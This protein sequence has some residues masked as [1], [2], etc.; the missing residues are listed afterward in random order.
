MP[1]FLRSNACSW[2]F[3]VLYLCN[4]SSYM[5]LSWPLVDYFTQGLLLIGYRLHDDYEIGK[6]LC[7]KAW[8]WFSCLSLSLFSCS[9]KKKLSLMNFLRRDD[10]SNKLRYSLNKE[11]NAV[12]KNSMSQNA[13][14][15]VIGHS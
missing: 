6:Q 7:S 10:L 15:G 14:P 12:K 8:L 1:I 13:F 11:G 3:N 4:F 5:L 2:F 9:N